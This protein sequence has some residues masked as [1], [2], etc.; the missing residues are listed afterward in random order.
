MFEEMSE[1]R[2]KNCRTSRSLADSTTYEQ[3]VILD[4]LSF[5]ELHDRY[6]KIAVAHK[7]TFEWIFDDPGPGCMPWLRGGRQI[8]WIRGKPGSGNSTLVKLL[9]DDTRTS[10]AFRSGTPLKQ[11]V[12]NF[13]LHDRGTPLQ[14]R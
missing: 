6:D 2:Q 14:N 7:E 9:V 8:Y 1:A 12:A 13:F 5:P 11:A 4:S 3:A 10:A